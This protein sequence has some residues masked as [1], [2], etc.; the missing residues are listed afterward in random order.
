MLISPMYSARS[1]TAIPTAKSTI[2]SHGPTPELSPSKPW[3]ENSGYWKSPCVV[4]ERSNDGAI[5]AAVP[6]GDVPDRF[7]LRIVRGATHEREPFAG[8]LGLANCGRRTN[9]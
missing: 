6:A 2:F 7:M 9:G 8:A 3:P 5:F 4:K 1:S